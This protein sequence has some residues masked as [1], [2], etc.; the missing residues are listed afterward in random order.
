M[1]LLAQLQ[2]AKGLAG[3][4]GKLS[5]KIA[6]K[7]CRSVT[8]VDIGPHGRS[9]AREGRSMVQRDGSPAGM[10]GVLES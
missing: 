5:L 7:L 4:C 9:T 8:M 1:G 3:N 2:S 10:S 6:H